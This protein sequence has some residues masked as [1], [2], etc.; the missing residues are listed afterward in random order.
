MRK[1][2]ETQLSS[3]IS[4]ILDKHIKDL[5]LFTTLGEIDTVENFEMDKHD[6][7][8]VKLKGLCKEVSISRSY[9]RLRD[10]WTPEHGYSIDYRKLILSQ[11]KS[12]SITRFNDRVGPSRFEISEFCSM[13]FEFSRHNVKLEDI[14]STL[15][16]LKKSY[17]RMVGL[18]D[19]NKLDE[20]NRQYE[21]TSA[22]SALVDISEPTEIK[23]S[24]VEIVKVEPVEVEPAE[25]A[26][27]RL[28]RF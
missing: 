24:G 20:H 8:K 14:A 17:E 13:T 26:E 21:A 7:F 2:S 12:R 28:S 11:D 25:P 1:S 27:T 22:I 23:L 6:G 9:V 10:E 15:D 16:E 19:G 4:S 5:D 3:F 18:I